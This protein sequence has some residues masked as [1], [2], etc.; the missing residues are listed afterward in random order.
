MNPQQE[1]VLG[2]GNFKLWLRNDQRKA[3]GDG[4]FIFEMKT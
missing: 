2:A 4:G 1:P 3:S